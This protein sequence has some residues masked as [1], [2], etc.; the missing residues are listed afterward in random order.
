MNVF[1]DKLFY[2]IFADFFQVS[3]QGGFTASYISF[4]TNLKKEFSNRKVSRC[5][6]LFIDYVD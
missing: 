4:H 3:Q 2:P 5:C 6:G 1:F